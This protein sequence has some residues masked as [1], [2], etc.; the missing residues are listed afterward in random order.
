MGQNK[1]AVYALRV[2][3]KDEQ[4]IVYDMGAEEQCLETQQYTELTGFFQFNAENQETMVTYVD[5][6]E[7]CTWKSS[8]KQWTAMKNVSNT[9]G[10]IHSVHPVASKVYYVRMLLHHE[11]LN[12]VEHESYQEVWGCCNM[13]KSGMKR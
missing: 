1:P 11:H 6:P 2:H 4:Q 13:I 12:G 10:R 5:F 3:L 7:S 9:I 8:D